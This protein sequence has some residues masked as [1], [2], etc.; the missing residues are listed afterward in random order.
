MS[1]KQF[2]PKTKEELKKLVED[3]KINLG[4]IDTS[5]ITDM[6]ELFRN[7][8]REDFSGI[9]T[10]DVSNV[11]N[12]SSMFKGCKEFNQPLNSWNTNKVKD[13][14]RMFESCSNFN[15]PLNNWDTSNVGSMNN[16]FQECKS[17]N[18]DISNWNVSKVT[19]MNSMFNGCTRFNQN[20]SNWNIKSIKYMSFMFANA[21]S[22]NQDLN[23][24]D[25]SKVK[26]ISFILNRANSF[27][28]IPYK[29]NFDNIKEDIE[30][31]LPEE[32]LDEIYSKKEP[33]NLLCYL[34]YDKYYED[35][36]LQKVDVKLWHK[37]LKNSINKKI[38]SFVSRLEKDFENELKDEKD[39]VDNNNAHFQNIEEAE[40]YVNNNYDK[41]FDKS[42]K[43]IDDK[44]TIFTKDRKT[45]ISLKMIRFIY[46]SYLKVKDNVVRL[47]IIDDIINLLDIESFINA[48]YEIFLSGRSKLASRII[49]G[50]YGD[51]KIVEDYVKSLKKEF[52]P[53]S[54]YV[55][56]LALNKN[57]Y[58]LK[59]LCDTSLKSKIESIKNAA[60]L[61]LETI[62]NRMKLERYELDDLLVPDFNL[63]KNGERIVYAEDKEYKLFI[64]D[65]M[66][67][68]I[69]HNNKELKTAPKTFSKELKSEIT[70]IKKEIKN[71][72]KSQ[73]DKMIYLLMNGRKYS[74]NFWKSVYIDNYFFNGYA[75]KLIWNLYDEN[76]L[77]L[78]T[79]RYLTDGSFTDYNDNE[80]K[81]NENNSI[82]LAYIKEMD[83]DI[84][85]KWKKQL[86]D[87]E[88]VQPINQL[89]VIDDLE[90]EFYSYNGEYKL[91]KLKNFVNK[92]PF[93]EYY[94]DYYTIDGYK[95]EE[96]VSGLALDISTN[97]ISRDNADFGD[98]IEI[99][100]KI[101]NISENNK[102]LVDR[103]MFGCIL[104]L[105]YLRTM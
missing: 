17:F 102:D 104:M 62:S 9:E 76:N 56:I 69:M 79:F 4:N 36:N 43:F 34:F 82:S 68:H 100:L 24:W 98:M 58:A 80:V 37:T 97:G 63:D 7:S 84:I 57:K 83:N 103:F 19:N 41:S 73:R 86:S 6:S 99:V 2:K 10:W 81:I 47:E 61:A 101:L 28:I 85:E 16:M 44:Y 39:A 48:S 64:D 33:I 78:T 67:L 88:I 92:Y 11:E 59:L 52:Y 21:S 18:Q 87:Y 1:E 38:I 93:N 12:M 77:F 49:C 26:R 13:M 72:V 96:K 50:I 8:E 91:S 45:K 42:I 75:V 94:E 60:E 35:E 20:I 40:E 53:R 29:W 95:F 70:F 30:Y 55:Y 27:K 15:Q 3:E 14:S 66:E 74:Y 105:E 65:N 71:I 51:G 23:N 22:F 89:R 31:I 25:I 46:G 5:L 90:K 32:M 54:Y